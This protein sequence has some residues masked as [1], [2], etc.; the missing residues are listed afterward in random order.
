MT[1]TSHPTGWPFRADPPLTGQ[2]EPGG[3]ALESPFLTGGPAQ[4]HA[5]AEPE[6]GELYEPEVELA[7]EE[8]R[9]LTELDERALAPDQRDDRVGP[10]LAEEE[11]LVDVGEQTLVEGEEEGP[12]TGPPQGVSPLAVQAAK[13]WDAQDRPKGWQGRVYGLVVHTTGGGLP[14][15]ARDK[16]VYH[17][18]HAV[19]YY[20]RSH[21]CHY[22][23]GWRG[24]E[25]GDLLQV[26]NE[27]EQAAGVGVTTPKN[28]RTDQRRSIERGRF[29]ADLP[30]DLVARWRARWPGYK[31]SLELLP[32]T[33]TANSCYVHVECVPCVFAYDGKLVSAAE[34]LRPGLRFTRAQH[35][36]V[37]LLA[38]DVARRNGWPRDQRWWRSPRLLGHEDLTPISRHTSTGGWDP[39]Y[40]RKD[41]YFDWD[42]VY[43]AIERLQRGTGAGPAGSAG[44][45]APAV[46]ADQLRDMEF[47]SDDDFNGFGEYA[48]ERWDAVSLSGGEPEAADGSGLLPPRDGL[49]A[50]ED[51]LANEAK[52][53]PDAESAPDKAKAT[54][55][56]QASR[57]GTDEDAVM[58]ALR[59]LLPSEMAEV[60]ADPTIVN[61]LHSELSGA[62][63]AAAEAQLARGRVGSMARV[64]IER[65][66]A[67]PARHSFGTFAAA[68]A[69][70]V[71]LGHQEA[72]DSTGIGTIHGNKCAAPKPP[73]ARA[74]DCTVYVIEVLKRAFA[75]IG[76]AD[77]WRNVLDEATTRSGPKL[78]G[79]EIIRALQMKCSWEAIFWAPDPRN[80]ADKSPEHPA[81]YQNVLQKGTY[82]I[83]K[84]L[85][86]DQRKLVINYRR[87]SASSAKDMS[88]IER[89]QRLQ[90]GVL[91]ARGG[92]HM[93]LVVNGAVYEVHESSP[94]NDRNAIEATPL[95]TFGW[96]SGVIAAPPGDLALAWRVPWSLGDVRFRIPNIR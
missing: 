30:A 95:E 48:P 32:G 43:Q 71:L 64:D 6:L 8:E 53:E 1:S 55:R 21:G 59:G 4:P 81:A 90:F 20:N 74:S 23:N 3:R 18:V 87:T 2:E 92:T 85:P 11:L 7:P 62:E 96:Q 91:A 24:V 17:T 94:A 5:L 34:P 88:G 33:R 58:S 28:P 66:L 40:L 80:P 36:T 79:T 16:G 47:E 84:G 67:S 44:E 13:Q 83:R 45:R 50:H 77:A 56:A 70:D 19:K 10:G 9:Y 12:A 65:I 89:L 76:R 69:R 29:E 72:F 82:P 31:H 51:D 41:R 86:V 39:G 68:V 26:A 57:W 27:R 52:T 46:L 63:L 75:G 38:C 14:A 15:E 37:V 78:K 61:L 42:Y 60:S 25:G 35:D 73:A 93:A 54:I 22:V 49:V